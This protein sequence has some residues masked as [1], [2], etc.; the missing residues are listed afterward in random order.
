MTTTTYDDEAELLRYSGKPLQLLP[1]VVRQ[2][3]K[4]RFQIAKEIWDLG[5]GPR[6]II[7]CSNFTMIKDIPF[8]KRSASFLTGNIGKLHQ[9]AATMHGRG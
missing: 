9:D 2:Y 6:R 3:R 7:F 5:L 4:S 8:R 1:Q